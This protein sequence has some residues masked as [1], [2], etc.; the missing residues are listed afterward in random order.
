MYDR[1]SRFTT[2]AKGYLEI[3]IAAPHYIRTLHGR[4]HDGCLGSMG[5]GSRRICTHQILTIEQIDP[6]YA[7]PSR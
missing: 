5:R 3:C 1:V 6:T 2:H 7:H 4:G